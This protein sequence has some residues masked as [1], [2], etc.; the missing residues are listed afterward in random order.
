[1]ARRRLLWQYLLPFLAIT[2]L[3]LVI[4]SW[5][6]TRAIDQFHLEQTRKE[7]EARARV[8]AVQA[9]Q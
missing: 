4:A 2:L 7:L 6:F 3:A 8:V 9:H 1:M 5:L